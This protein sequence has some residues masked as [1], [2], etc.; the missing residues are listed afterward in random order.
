[1]R[2]NAI[3]GAVA[4]TFVWASGFA[5]ERLWAALAR[6]TFAVVGWMLH[7][8]YPFVL[9]DPHR[10][11]I[12]TPTFAAVITPQCSG[13]EGIGLITAFLSVYLWLFRRELRF[14]D[15]L[16]LLP[17]GAAVIW[18]ANAMRIV[19]LIAIGTAGW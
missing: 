13:Y 5:T 4:G 10:M 2:A 3:A 7:L 19:A 12:G 16:L 1:Q 17:L 6:V 14:P 15:V 11:L 18:I 8:I 9:K